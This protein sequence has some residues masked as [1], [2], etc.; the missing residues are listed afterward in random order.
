MYLFTNG[1]SYKNEQW[2]GYISMN[3]T[4]YTCIL[5]MRN[6]IEQWYKISTFQSWIH[7]CHIK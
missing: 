3:F 7:T 5:L 6:T 4:A 2:K 1:M